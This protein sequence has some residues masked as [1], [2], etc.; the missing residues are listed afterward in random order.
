MIVWNNS[1]AKLNYLHD[2]VEQAS[3]VIHHPGVIRGTTDPS[4]GKS[5]F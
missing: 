3:S 5:N 4:T 1:G 2:I